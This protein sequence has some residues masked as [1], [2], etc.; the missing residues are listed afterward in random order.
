MRGMPIFY[1]ITLGFSFGL[2]ALSFFGVWPA[3]ISYFFTPHGHALEERVGEQ[4]ALEGVVVSEPEAR[5]NDTRYVVETSGSRV[6]VYDEPYAKLE[7]GDKV[8]VAGKLEK[9]EKFLTDVGREFDY[10]A[11]LAKDGIYYIVRFANVKSVL[12]NAGLPVKAG[13]PV[14]AF[15]FRVK[16]AFIKNLE[17]AIPFPESGLGAGITVAGKQALPKNVLDEFNLTGTS[18]VVVLS[19]YNVTIVAEAL[20]SLLAFLPSAAGYAGGALCIILFTLM[21]GGTATVVRAALMALI[22]IAGKLAR[23]H[24]DVLRALFVAV[25]FMLVWNPMLLVYDPSFQLSVL[26]TFGIILIPKRITKYFL[27]LTERFQIRQIL[28]STISA[29]IAVLPLIIYLTGAFSIW[30]VLANALLALVIPLTMFLC[31]LTG[32]FG[33]VANFL[34]LPFGFVAFAFLHAELALVHFFSVLPLASIKLF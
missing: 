2:F 9:P 19:G 21:A 16:N 31:F 7:Y 11:Y 24:Y 18:Q 34:A 32:F 14:K 29:Q 13:N 23:R 27:W 5:E 3:G 26:A 6:M 22:V 4:V 30:S 33:F 28:V 12:D 10:P 8:S 25:F 20:S 15:L 1:K 17:R